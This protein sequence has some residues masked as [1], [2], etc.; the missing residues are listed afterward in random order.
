[1]TGE[2]LRRRLIFYGLNGAIVLAV[3]FAI[4]EPI[5]SHFGLRNDEILDSAAQL[6]QVRRVAHDTF[7]LAKA[8]T[9]EAD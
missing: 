1:M 8:S 5:V 6:A 7:R 9:P 4:F 2:L 3:C